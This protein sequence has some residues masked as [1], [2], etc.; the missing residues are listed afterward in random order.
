MYRRHCSELARCFS[1]GY[2][3]LAR[4]FA[5]GFQEQ[6]LFFEV[7]LISSGSAELAGNQT[8]TG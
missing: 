5:A 8:R 4:C 1:A 3:E 7:G 6:A 2:R